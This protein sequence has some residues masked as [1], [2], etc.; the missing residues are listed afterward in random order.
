MKEGCFFT[1][2][3]DYNL[4][5]IGDVDGMGAND[6]NN[7]LN[8]PV[9]KQVLEAGSGNLQID[10]DADLKA[11]DYLVNIFRNP[12]QGI[13]LARNMQIGE[14][15]VFGESTCITSA[16][17]GITEHSYTTI[18]G[19]YD[20][21]DAVVLQATEITA[22]GCDSPTDYGVSS[23]FSNTAGVAGTGIDYGD[24]IDIGVGV[25]VD[26]YQTENID[27]GPYHFLS[28]NVYLGSCVD[29]D[30]GHS[31]SEGSTGDDFST[32]LTI[33]GTC[34]VSGDDEDA[35]V[36]YDLESGVVGNI[37][38]ETF[39]STSIASGTQ[40]YLQAWADWD[41]NGDFSDAGEQIVTDMVI[42]SA[43]TAIVQNIPVTAPVTV[44]NGTA[45]NLRIRISDHSGLSYIGEA[46]TGEV[47]DHIVVVGTSII[48][49][50]PTLSSGDRA[51]RTVQ[52]SVNLDEI[53]VTELEHDISSNDD[54]SIDVEESLVLNEDSSD[55]YVED[56][57]DPVLNVAK[58]QMIDSVENL[59]PAFCE[60]LKDNYRKEGDSGLVVTFIQLFLRL[61]Q[62][63]L[64]QIDGNFGEQTVEAVKRFQLKFM[65]E[66]L[67][68]WGLNRAT[69]FWFQATE[70][71][72]RQI[73]GCPTLIRR[74]DNGGILMKDENN[75]VNFQGGGIPLQESVDEIYKRYQFEVDSVYE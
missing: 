3:T 21:S 71:K 45:V 5:D 29:A 34:D 68:P 33:I 26:N 20:V 73:L 55:I 50:Q 12:T 9:I 19:G 67:A 56:L 38:I 10:Y 51:R 44:P 63:E 27:N 23:I 70:F 46:K 47:E 2:A 32:G 13:D 14:A 18:G 57:V 24:A 60:N 43:E 41:G 37:S 69:G 64:L 4:N 74:L 54:G 66:I 62:G 49:E 58:M 61:F 25:G 65:S 59:Q 36:S 35:L 52:S 31:P 28:P 40:I 8:H 6:A 11:G 22:G 30:L 48:P 15:E 1:S 53:T 42:D 72:A 17:T 75:N 39:V 7:F 16:G